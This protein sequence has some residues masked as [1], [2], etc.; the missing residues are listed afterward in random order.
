MSLNKKRILLVDS[1]FP[2]EYT[3]W[4]NN[5]IESLISE[6]DVDIIVYKTTMFAGI[7]YNFNYEFISKQFS[8]KKYNIFICDPKYKSIQKFNNNFNGTK[9]IGKYSFSYMFSLE[10]NFDLDKYDCIYYLFLSSYLKFKKEFNVS[11]KINLID[12]FTGGGLDFNPQSLDK[13]CYYISNHKKTSYFLAKNNFK[14]IEC[15][16]LPQ[17]R[18]IDSLI[19]SKK[20][21]KS[22]IFTVNFSSMGFGK[23]K[24]DAAYLRIARFYKMI[25]PW[26]KIRFIST[27]NCKKSFLVKNFK[28]FNYIDL[29]VHFRNEVDIHINLANK[30]ALN[31]WPLGTEAIKGGCILMSTDPDNQKK[32]YKYGDAILSVHGILDTVLKIRRL[33]LDP[34]YYLEIQKAQH[35]FFVKYFGYNNQQRT[36]FKFIWKIISN[37]S[38]KNG[39]Y[40]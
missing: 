32:Y 12:L 10:R 18:K 22:T 38:L 16:G 24:G 11:K 6:F 36:R 39:Y 34:N 4:R 31:T 15:L 35:K 7:K 29:I 27:G 3:I 40:V 14:F 23:E 21:K 28:P 9:L 20:N 1:M 2:N 33:Y 30:K 26:H 17:S 25:F 5:L 8:L 37:S 19:L 13:N